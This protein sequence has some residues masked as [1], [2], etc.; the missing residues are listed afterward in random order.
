MKS[1]AKEWEATGQLCKITQ[2]KQKLA[3][4][5]PCAKWLEPKWLRIYPELP[6]HPHGP[7]KTLK[8]AVLGAKILPKS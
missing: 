1:L 2:A 4:G 8:K 6:R 3:Q 5:G 7:S